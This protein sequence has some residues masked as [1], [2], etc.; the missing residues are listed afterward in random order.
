[1][2]QLRFSYTIGCVA[3]HLRSNISGG[4][5][6]FP[7]PLIVQP[8]RERFKEPPQP[9]NKVELR[10]FTIFW[11]GYANVSEQVL[12]PRLNLTIFCVSMNAIIQVKTQSKQTLPVVW[13]RR[14]HGSVFF[15]HTTLLWALAATLTH[16]GAFPYTAYVL[17]LSQ[18][19][20]LV[21]ALFKNHS[22]HTRLIYTAVSVCTAVAT[23]W[24][25]HLSQR[26]QIIGGC[27]LVGAP[28]DGYFLMYDSSS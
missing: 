4:R 7:H 15:L 14:I 21:V 25:V 22:H 11:Y 17:R 18:A 19:Y 8:K 27:L 10:L 3:S 5:L 16:R 2:P 23:C 6:R 13:C 1:M 9:N 12:S 28:Y 26:M 24:S 20:S